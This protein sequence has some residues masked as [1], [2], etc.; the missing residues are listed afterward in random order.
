MATESI[1]HFAG[2]NKQNTTLGVCASPLAEQEPP[3]PGE[4]SNS[5]VPFHK[6]P[7]DTHMPHVYM[8][9]QPSD[10]KKRQHQSGIS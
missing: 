3:K 4:K 2:Y 6:R 8:D 10:P 1:L 5:C 9:K 7:L